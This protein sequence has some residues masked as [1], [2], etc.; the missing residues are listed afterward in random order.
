MAKASRDKNLVG[1]VHKFRVLED[2]ESKK[3]MV[4]K[5]TDAEKKSK[6]FVAILPRCLVTNFSPTISNQLSSELTYEGLVL[7]ILYS[8]I[9]VISLQPELVALKDD[10]LKKS[11]DDDG[12]SGALSSGSTHIGVVNGVVKGGQI[13]VRFFNG[14]QKSMKV[15]HL[16][17]TQNYQKVYNPGKVIRVAVNK[18]DALSTKQGV[19]DACLAL[20][21]K[22]DESDKLVQIQSFSK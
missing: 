8:S 14:I 10:I 3:Y 19:I 2:V 6:N 18:L 4:V 5:S 20:K 13:S 12:K 21:G 16:N 17:T 15:K 7:E 11:E 9:P 1:K 22:A